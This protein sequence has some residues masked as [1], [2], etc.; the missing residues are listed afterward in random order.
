MK[1]QAIVYV[2]VLFATAFAVSGINFTG[3]FRIKHEIEAKVFVMLIILGIS[4]AASQFI[5]NF[6]ET[7]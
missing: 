4:Y 5:I 6:I 2:I 3:F 7:I 1:Y